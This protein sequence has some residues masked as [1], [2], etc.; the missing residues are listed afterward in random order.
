MVKKKLV[1][2]RKFQEPFKKSFFQTRQMFSMF[3]FS[4]IK[5]ICVENEKMWKFQDEKRRSH[6]NF[7]HFK[8]AH[9]LLGFFIALNEKFEGGNHVKVFF[10]KMRHGCYHD[11]HSRVGR[12]AHERR[13]FYI[14]LRFSPFYFSNSSSTPAP[15]LASSF[16]LSKNTI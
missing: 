15:Y 10:W 12:F 8:I 16:L 4:E 2:M 13:K 7:N 6:K 5:K 14:F 1:L 11:E 9:P 3:F